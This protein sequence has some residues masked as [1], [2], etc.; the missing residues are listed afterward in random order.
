M[1]WNYICK[2]FKTVREMI[3]QDIETCKQCMLIMS[4]LEGCC[5]EIAPDNKK[6]WIFSNEFR[7]L[8]SEIH[9]E[10]E[11]MDETDYVSCEGILNSYLQEFYDLCDS[12]KV[13]L[14]I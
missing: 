14:D 2:G 8:K 7:D 9:D 6:D 5:D 13:W 11:Y 10:I 1:K 3:N 4:E 12:A